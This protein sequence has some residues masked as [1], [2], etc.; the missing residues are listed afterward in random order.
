MQNATENDAFLAPS[1]PASKLPAQP[2]PKKGRNP[3]GSAKK[4][5]GGNANN[6]SQQSQN[7]NKQKNPEVTGASTTGQVA[8]AAGAGPGLFEDIA[9]GASQEAAPQNQDVNSGNK[10]AQQLDGQD[11]IQVE[12]GDG[13]DQDEWMQDAGKKE[14]E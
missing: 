9:G 3:A 13:G 2:G 5:K 11:E 10:R 14:N 4:P 8:G 12:D 1:E 6:S 7:S